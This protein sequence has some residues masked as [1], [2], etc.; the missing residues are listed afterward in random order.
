MCT[1]PSLITI[2]ANNNSSLSQTTTNPGDDHPG[3]AAKRRP[4]EEPACTES[5][6]ST[7]SNV[8]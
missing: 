5:Q 7:A 2:N 8:E 1:D 4:Q 6:V 3:V